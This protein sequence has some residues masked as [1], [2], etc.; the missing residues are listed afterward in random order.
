M[1]TSL[2]LAR[3]ESSSREGNDGQPDILHVQDQRVQFARFAAV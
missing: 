1:A 3:V 2:L